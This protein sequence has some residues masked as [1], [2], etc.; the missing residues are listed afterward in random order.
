MH[1]Y[2]NTEKEK[3]ELFNDGREIAITRECSHQ[4]IPFY[5]LETTEDT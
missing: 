1:Y 4:H 2:L 5:F 3:L